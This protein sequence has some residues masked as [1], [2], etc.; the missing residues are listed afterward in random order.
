MIINELQDADPQEL[1]D[2][3]LAWCEF[4]ASYDIGYTSLS[5]WGGYGGKVEL[6][7]HLASETYPI[8]L[9]EFL[10]DMKNPDF[11]RR[12]AL[13]STR[14]N[15]VDVAKRTE[16]DLMLFDEGHPDIAESAKNPPKSDMR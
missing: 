7:V 14:K 2:A 16:E 15:L 13:L 9:Q 4:C 5:F 12:R 6:S 1:K 8:E 10:E 11:I 3:L